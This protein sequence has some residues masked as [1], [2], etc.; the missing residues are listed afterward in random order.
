MWN[1]NPASIT[2]TSAPEQKLAENIQLKVQE[3]AP[4]IDS[5]QSV[6]ARPI[7]KK[8]K[9]YAY[10]SAE[11]YEAASIFGKQPANMSGVDLQ[12]LYFDAEGNLIV[13]D[14]LMQLIEHFML[15]SKEEG[16]D[17]AIARIKEYIELTLPSP[18]AAQAIA[19]TDQYINYKNRAD[20]E[21]P[22]NSYELD[23]DV[24]VQQMESS[25][26][27]RKKLRRETLAGEV[28]EAFF[29]D[30]ER[31]DDFSLA[32]AKASTN[33]NLTYEERDALIAQAELTLP[34][35]SQ[36]RMRY[37]R[38]E[39]N[40]KRHVKI[41][42]S[43]EGKQSE[44]YQL[45]KDFYGKQTADRISYYEDDSDQWASRVT[46]FNQDQ[47]NI[48][49]QDSLSKHQKEDQIAG[50]KASMFSEKEMV[51]LAVQSIRSRVAQVR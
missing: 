34:L 35:K 7:T 4:S 25:L 14:N 12:K 10:L 19:I 16:L 43:E 44:V 37:V 36:K 28:V 38:E 48:L 32:R 3:G 21:E 6:T 46:Q 33:E 30:E 22:I 1:D 45:R 42:K 15:A 11:K 2:L 24:L 8:Q 26:V 51:K 27:Q 9:Q 23:V 20:E 29:G 13:T 41:L 50:L 40:L 49:Q 47:I 31:Y 18:A 39:K 17:Q 5:E